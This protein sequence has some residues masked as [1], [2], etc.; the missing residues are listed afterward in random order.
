MSKVD[1]YQPRRL[2]KKNEKPLEPDGQK[3]QKPENTPFDPFVQPQEGVLV[4]FYSEANTPSPAARAV[5]R[6][7]WELERLI[8]AASNG[9]LPT[10][11][12]RLENGIVADFERYVL[13]W[14]AAYLTGATND[15]TTRLWEAWRTWQG[16]KVTA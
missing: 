15:A 1:T 4:N 3:G 5:P 9:S 11:M 13:S 10:G 7:S 14:A 2:Q 6:L 12:Q 16:Q 8:S